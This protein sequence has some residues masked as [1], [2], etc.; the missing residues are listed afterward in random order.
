MYKDM[1]KISNRMRREIKCENQLKDLK[2]LLYVKWRFVL[3]YPTQ[4]VSKQYS[5]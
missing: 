5:T 3:P 4:L 2:I 1:D